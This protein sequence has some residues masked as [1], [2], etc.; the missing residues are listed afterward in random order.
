MALAG[1]GGPTGRAGAGAV[2]GAGP[3]PR[4]GL[5]RTF[6]RVCPE[7]ENSPAIA[8]RRV[9]CTRCDLLLLSFSL[10]IS[11]L[12]LFS[13]HGELTGTLVQLGDLLGECKQKSAC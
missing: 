9:A 13:A 7:A 2:G 1:R 6:L 12:S 11:V 5:S 3:C 4:R 8:G 10:A